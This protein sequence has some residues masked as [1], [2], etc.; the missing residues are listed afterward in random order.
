M[1]ELRSEGS[2]SVLASGSKEVWRSPRGSTDET[3]RVM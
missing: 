1:A 2:N 3:W